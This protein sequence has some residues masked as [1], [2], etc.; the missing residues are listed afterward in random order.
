MATTKTTVDAIESI[1]EVARKEAAIELQL[2]EVLLE[3]NPKLK[4]KIKS[5]LSKIETY[6]L[7]AGSVKLI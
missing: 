7:E 5:R 3:K 1:T 4:E 6:H 2:L